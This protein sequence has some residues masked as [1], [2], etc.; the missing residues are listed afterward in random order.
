MCR[1]DADVPVLNTKN[2]SE[3][4]KFRNL[5]DNQ[6]N[7]IRCNKQAAENEEAHIYFMMFYMV[8]NEYSIY[9][10]ISGIRFRVSEG[11]RKLFDPVISGTAD[12]FTVKDHSVK[13]LTVPV[14]AVII[15]VDVGTSFAVFIFRDII[16]GSS[17]LSVLQAGIHG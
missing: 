7:I 9:E 15:S 17:E 13:R 11:G 5:S 6:Y 10:Q 3:K 2:S 16:K 14:I 1:I 4:S 12:I 8:F